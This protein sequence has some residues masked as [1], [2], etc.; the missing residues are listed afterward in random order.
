MLIVYLSGPI[1]C[2]NYKEA[3]E[4]R[5]WVAKELNDYD[6][7]TISPMRGKGYLNNEICLS[8]SYE[9]TLMSNN[10]AIVTRD[11]FDTIRSDIL[12]LNLLG[13]K[14]VSIGSMIELGWASAN[15]IPVITVADMENDNIH[16]HGFIKE[17]SGWVVNDLETAIQVIKNLI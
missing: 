11:K 9:K 4:W 17:L 13:A 8:E 12:L 1:K 5:D 6:I 15:D 3:V 14:K 16:N 10:K 7:I 2:L